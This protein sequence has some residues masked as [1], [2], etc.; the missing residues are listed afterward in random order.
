[1]LCSFE[2]DKTCS[3]RLPGLTSKLET[4]LSE[5]SSAR[6]YEKTK[7]LIRKASSVSKGFAELLC[8]SET[9]RKQRKKNLDSIRQGLQGIMST[10][11]AGI[12]SR[13][14]KELCAAISMLVAR[15]SDAGSTDNE[16]QVQKKLAAADIIAGT[17]DIN[18]DGLQEQ[19]RQ[20]LSHKRS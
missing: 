8:A 18:T 14:W 12:S 13:F 2:A 5:K 19:W 10:A 9:W 7:L 16:Q 1:M 4:L 17:K 3:S 20:Y 6:T 15:L 11:D